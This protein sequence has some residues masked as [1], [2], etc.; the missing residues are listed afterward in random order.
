M[1]SGEAQGGSAAARVLS[2]AA[3][4][5]LEARAALVQKA[6]H[7][8][9]D[10]AG[11]A[12]VQWA[13][14]SNGC[15]LCAACAGRHRGLGVQASFVRSL[16]LDAWRESELA[17]VLCG[18]NE[19]VNAFLSRAAAGE[20][21]Q[22]RYLSPA[23]RLMRA[24]LSARAAGAPEPTELPDAEVE[25]ARAE[26][27]AYRARIAAASSSTAERARSRP[28][29]P[30]SDAPECMICRTPFTML[31]RRHHCRSCGRCCCRICAPKLNSKPIPLLGYKV[32]VRHCKECFRS[33]HLSFAD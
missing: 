27:R 31:N 2:G 6:G 16:E 30:D 21:G 10:C 13:S 11:G 24:A 25:A 1:E 5:G 28:W 32:P 17:R 23:G 29:V 22:E 18:G 3:P 12:P 15:L 4:L 26:L 19:W 9:A 20:A 7:R 14:V 8:C 33:A